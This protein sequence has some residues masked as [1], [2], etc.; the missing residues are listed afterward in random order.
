MSET[1]KVQDDVFSKG[2]GDAWFE[3]NAKALAAPERHDWVL[4]NLAR[5]APAE[6][7]RSVCEVGCSN[8]WRLARLN[9]SL[10]AVQRR[11]GFDLS[12][13]AIRDGMRMDST[14]DLRVGPASAPPFEEQ[15]DLVIVSFVL[16][17]VDRSM[18]SRSLAAIDALVVPGGVLVVADFLPDSQCRRRYHHRQDV[19]LYT[20]K[21]DYAKAFTGM[22]LY[23]ELQRSTFHHGDAEGKV[24]DAG[25]ADRAVCVV[26]HKPEQAYPEQ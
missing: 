15:F 2:E 22:G 8:G 21:Q 5:L 9:E 13:S 4:T 23:R 25:S 17:W 3:R 14:L 6:R 26:L 20:F 16:H 18:L 11:A 1:M 12:E 24:D 19:A 7:L 10:P